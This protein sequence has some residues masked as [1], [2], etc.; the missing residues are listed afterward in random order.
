MA[1]K[2][3]YVRTKCQTSV[4]KLDTTNPKTTV[5]RPTTEDTRGM[6]GHVSSTNIE[7]GAKKYIIPVERVSITAITFGW[8]AKREW[9][10]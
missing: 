8:S 3:P 6:D 5:T 7:I 1:Y 2:A 9:V 10:V 4:E